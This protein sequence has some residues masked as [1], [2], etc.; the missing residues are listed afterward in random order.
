MI[1]KNKHGAVYFQFPHLA[2]SPGVGHGIFTRKGGV[3][4]GPFCGLNVGARVGDDE[5]NT[6]ANRR[7]V[8]SVMGAKIGV[9]LTQTHGD[10][11]VVLKGG[12]QTSDPA[13][14]ASPSPEGDAAITD[15]P[16]VFLFMQTADCQAILIADPV[17]RAVAN[18]HSGWRGSVANVAGKTVE[19]MKRR[20]D[21]R[22]E[23][24][25]AGIGP[26][27]GPCCAEFSNFK[28]EFPESLFKYSDS[29]AYF[30]FWAM[31]R[32]QLRDA[33]I[34]DSNIR[35]SGICSKCNPDLF[36][37]YR[38]EKVTGRFASAIGLI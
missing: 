35:A 23:N 9:W 11:T 33:G 16:G 2:N 25:L 38:K 26:S 29:R 1:L 31:T 17:A 22:P 14:L 32:D 37:S 18:V 28:Q 12:E 34:P 30:D 5:K 4:Q 15:I 24:M 8:E 21:C 10:G 6:A 19:K 27:L 20:F 3:G 13:G 7:L 36:F